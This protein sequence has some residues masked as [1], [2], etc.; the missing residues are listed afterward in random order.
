MKSVSNDLELQNVL[1]EEGK[2]LVLFSADW[3]GPCKILK[4]NLEKISQEVTDLSIL[5]ANV[6]ETEEHTKRFGIKNIPTCILV[7]NDQELG[8]FTGVKTP[9]QIKKFILEHNN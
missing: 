2:K 4:P 7:E 3:C 8:R 1:Q 6:S 5:K 9:D